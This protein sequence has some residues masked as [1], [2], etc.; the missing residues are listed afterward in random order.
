VKLHPLQTLVVL[1]ASALLIG[2]SVQRGRAMGKN[3]RMESRREANLDRQAREQE[4]RY[5][6]Q[7]RA[8][9]KQKVAELKKYTQRARTRLLEQE[10]RG[11][12]AW[13]GSVLRTFQQKCVTCH[14][15]PDS[16]YTTDRAWL[17]RVA[18]T[19]CSG[20]N[21]ESRDTL[22]SYLTTVEGIQPR[23]IVSESVPAPNQGA[24][25]SNLGSGELLLRRNDGTVYRLVWGSGE[26]GQRRTVPEGSY[27]LFGFRALDGI[28][29]AAAAGGRTPVNVLPGGQVRLPVDTSMKLELTHQRRDQQVQVALRLE[30]QGGMGVGLYRGGVPIQIPVV[31]LEGQEI[32]AEGALRSAGTGRYR[33]TLAVPD[34]V[35]DGRLRVEL[36]HDLPF[37]TRGP[38]V[39]KL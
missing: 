11:E 29:H 8:L 14:A 24:V 6:A 25:S 18:T 10:K 9:A 19:V 16:R 3:G 15:Y 21:P 36:P 27:T 35:T 20:M 17:N 39:V 13:S 22:A 2:A 26:Q 30:G 33:A 5:E 7:Q 28:Y 38:T 1:L 34:T 23:N 31:V 4:A 37:A 32:V 12:N